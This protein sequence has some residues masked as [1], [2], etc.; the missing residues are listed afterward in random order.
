MRKHLIQ[1]RTYYF[2]GSCKPQKHSP[3][4]DFWGN[5]FSREKALSK[6]IPSSTGKHPSLAGIYPTKE[7][8]PPSDMLYKAP[9]CSMHSR[10]YFIM[11][12]YRHNSHHL[13][14]LLTSCISRTTSTTSTTSRDHFCLRWV[15]AA[16]WQWQNNK[17][18]QMIN[19]KSFHFLK[20]Q[21]KTC[22]MRPALVGKMTDLSVTVKNKI[23]LEV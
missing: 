16:M 20:I 15:E 5:W 6:N 2:T 4:S 3:K 21:L 14:H 10:N 11:K 1:G 17:F 22:L 12:W 23:R 19:V 7:K 18:S 13:Q 9:W 8:I